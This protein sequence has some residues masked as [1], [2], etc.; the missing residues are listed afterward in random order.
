[1]K[2]TPS[3]GARIKAPWRKRATVIRDPSQRRRRYITHEEYLALFKPGELIWVKFSKNGQWEQLPFRSHRKTDGFGVYV[4][5]S[6]GS[7]S[8]CFWY[9]LTKPAEA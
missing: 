4:T 8:V 5:H 9:S 1:M 2:S 7:T 3:V 6:D